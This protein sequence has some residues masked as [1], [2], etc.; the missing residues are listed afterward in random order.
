MTNNITPA[1]YAQMKLDSMLRAGR[2]N[3]SS[4]PIEDFP[5]TEEQAREDVQAGIDAVDLT[6]RKDAVDVLLS[7]LYERTE[8]GMIP[9]EGTFT[10]HDFFDEVTY[11]EIMEEAAESSG[12][13]Q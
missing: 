1:A 11:T 10:G 4:F 12:L 5:R 9:A 6:F 13:D 7:K 8:I 2:E 3:Q